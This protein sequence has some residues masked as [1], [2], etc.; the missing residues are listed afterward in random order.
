MENRIL[1]CLLPA[2]A[3]LAC[4]LL[5]H[6]WLGWPRS[7]LSLLGL[8]GI[9]FAAGGLTSDLVSGRKG[10]RGGLVPIIV[11]SAG[12]LAGSLT[13]GR[14]WDVGI[15]LLEFK[16]KLVYFQQDSAFYLLA[17]E[18]NGPIDNVS[19]YFPAPT[20]DN[21]VPPTEEGRET[22]YSGYYVLY[23][24]DDNGNLL[25]QAE[26][27]DG[28]N[29]TVYQFYGER[30]KPPV[31]HDTGYS[32]DNE[33]CFFADW[34]DRLYPRE[35]WWR[36]TFICTFPDVADRLTLKLFFEPSRSGASVGKI[37]FQRRNMTELDKNIW[38]KFFVRLSKPTDHSLEKVEAF[39]RENGPTRGGMNFYLYPL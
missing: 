13:V 14:P 32:R 21:K 11:L 18:D 28:K 27:W 10:N 39:H 23:Y 17:T 38:L 16:P 2:A 20:V 37:D 26:T 5:L 31:L 34:I 24:L 33:Q 15:R 30:K 12:L 36:T 3:F 8:V 6:R 19:I 9:S 29:W 35:V 4:T 7:I 1:R 22:P 25:R